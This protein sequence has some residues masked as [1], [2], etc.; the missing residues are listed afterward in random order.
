MKYVVDGCLVERNRS[1]ASGGGDR[2]GCVKGLLLAAVV[3]HP[4][5]RPEKTIRGSRGA[6]C[7]V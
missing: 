6:D 5:S 2:L 4:L 1:P 3:G 7:E